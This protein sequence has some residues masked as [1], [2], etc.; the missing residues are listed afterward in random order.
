VAFSPGA[1]S[2][3]PDEMPGAVATQTLTS[4]FADIESWAAMAWLQGDVWAGVLADHHRLVRAAR[5]TAV[6]HGGQVVS[7]ATQSC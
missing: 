1:V 5:I 4:L 2:G 7:W 3:N 6:A